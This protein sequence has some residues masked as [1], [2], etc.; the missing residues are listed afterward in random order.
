MSATTEPE[1]WPHAG[2]VLAGGA[3]RRM[4]RSKHDL[5]LPDGRTMIEAVVAALAA[6]CARVVVAGDADVGLP[7]VADL[8]ADQGPLGG[9]EAVLAS[10]LDSQYLVCPCDVPLIT[11]ALL[12]RL[13][14]APPARAAVFRV[15]GEQ[16]IRPLPARL[17]AD[18]SGKVTALLDENRRAVG[19]FVRSVE[20]VVVPLDRAEAALLV[21]VNTPAEYEALR[22]ASL[23]DS[24]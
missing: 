2:V 21:N 5:A 6:V 14:A 4:G 10:G 18:L 15:E 7:R 9:I 17:S 19:D 16:G 12:R 23:S 24:A 20:P 1:R 11:G 3:A 22:K 8:R 13:L